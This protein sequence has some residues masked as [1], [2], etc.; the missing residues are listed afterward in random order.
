MD[1]EWQT[2]KSGLL[3][4]NKQM[5]NNPYLS[6]VLITCEGFDEEF[7][8][9]KYVLCTSS[10]V[11]DGMLNGDGF[12]DMFINSIHI[13]DSDPIS[14]LSFLTFLYTDDCSLLSSNIISVMS[15]AKKYNV[16]SLLHKCIQDISSILNP[17]KTLGI[18]QKAIEKEHNELLSECWKF[19][20]SF[21]DEVA[22]SEEF[23]CMSYDML[24]SLLKRKNLQIA[25]VDLFLAVLRW[26]DYHCVMNSFE[27]TPENRRFMMGDAIY[28]I[29][30]LAMTQEEFAQ[31][32]SPTRLLSFGEMVPIY[33]KF[34][35]VYSPELEWK[36]ATRERNPITIKCPKFSPTK[37]LPKSLSDN[38]YFL[39]SFSASKDI[40]LRGVCL[41]VKPN[42]K[43]TVYL[44]RAQPNGGNSCETPYINISSGNMMF[45][46]PIKV[47]CGSVVTLLAVMMGSSFGYYEVAEHI[48]TQV[49]DVV[50]TFIETYLPHSCESGCVIPEGCF[51]ELLFSV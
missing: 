38:T 9:H 42:E 51:E 50:V 7:Y 41:N 29:R 39:V 28:E 2:S 21:T 47:S 44:K 8:A 3:E 49:D 40:F 17:N 6:D 31:Y 27:L 14:I 35:G 45:T 5:L 30:F 37:I 16:P 36:E 26:S 12:A 1:L 19:V 23:S 33:E 13:I 20:E 43:V 22:N 25:E 10:S 18:L 24:V 46:K 48:V 34:N 4:R 11:L 15:L 32:V